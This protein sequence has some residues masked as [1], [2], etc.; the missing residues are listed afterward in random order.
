MRAEWKPWF[1]RTFEFGLPPD[2][3]MEYLERLARAPAR[4]AELLSAPGAN[5]S[6]R[7]APD[8]WSALEH[9]GHLW[10]LE[11]LWETRFIE[12]SE[13]K[14]VLA[15][16]DLTNRQTWDANFNTVEPNKILVGF[17]K[18][19]AKIVTFLHQAPPEYFSHKALHPRLQQPTSPVDLMY[20]I[21]EHD[22]HHLAMIRQMLQ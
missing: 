4:L 20:F 6:V 12:F 3:A 8:K 22:D 10:A 16:A 5:L 2:S 19:R 13:G 11:E 7:P 17:R 1:D 9:A 18:S 15:A 14:N 21:A